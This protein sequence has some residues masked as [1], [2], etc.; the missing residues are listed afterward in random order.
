MPLMSALRRLGHYHK[1]KANLSHTAKLCCKTKQKTSFM[2]EREH[3]VEDSNCAERKP[4]RKKS[5]L[6]KPGNGASRLKVEDMDYRLVQMRK[7]R[8]SLETKADFPS[9]RRYCWIVCGKA[10]ELRSISYQEDIVSL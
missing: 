8:T 10:W 9:G 5:D 6:S 7:L 2:K 3:G 1:F 4:A